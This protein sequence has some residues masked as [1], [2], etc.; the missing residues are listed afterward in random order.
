MLRLGRE[1]D[2][3]S[4]VDDQI[5][6]PTTSIE[7]ANA[8]RTIVDGILAGQFGEPQSWAGVYHMTCAGATSWFGFA[9]AIF[10]RRSGH[11]RQGAGIDADSERGVSHSGQAAAEFSAVE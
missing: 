6:A 7:L 5:G 11:G 4:I 10:A 2:R 9:Q 1:R 3:L 8:T